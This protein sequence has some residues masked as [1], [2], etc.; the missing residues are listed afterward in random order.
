M[1]EVKST[2]TEMR[3]ISD[4][5]IGRLDMA[6]RRTSEH[7]NI[8]I[9]MPETEKQRRKDQRKENRISKNSDIQKTLHR[10]NGTETIFKQKRTEKNI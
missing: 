1:L 6:E 9:E 4:G 5:F 2:V 8:S 7:E 10:H 3:S